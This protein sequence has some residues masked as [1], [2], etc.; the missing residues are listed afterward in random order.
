M[1]PSLPFPEKRGTPRVSR[2]NI[3]PCDIVV[4]RLPERKNRRG[5][6][7]E[8]FWRERLPF[9]FADGVRVS[10]AEIEPHEIAAVGWEGKEGVDRALYLRGLVG[11]KRAHLRCLE[12][13]ARSGTHALLL[14][15]DDVAFRENWR[16]L[17]EAA[18]AQAPAGWHQI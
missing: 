16:A 13:A 7:R 5:R 4:L 11:C 14:C 10:D 15:E 17:L 18:V 1:A 9:R 3:G 2:A 6:V 12:A 8:L